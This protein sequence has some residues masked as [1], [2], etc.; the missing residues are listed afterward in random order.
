MLGE[1]SALQTGNFALP[2]AGNLKT[3]LALERTV[4]N[5]HPSPQMDCSLQSSK[6]A[7]EMCL[8]T[9][10]V[11]MFGSETPAGVAWDRGGR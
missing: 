2:E 4:T 7:F 5:S 11:L 3:I 8:K 1:L 6:A 10:R 9:L